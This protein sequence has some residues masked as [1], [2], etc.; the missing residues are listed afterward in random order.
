MQAEDLSCSMVNRKIQKGS[1]KTLKKVILKNDNH[2]YKFQ[3]NIHVN[4]LAI[5][6]KKLLTRSKLYQLNYL[7][8]LMIY[9]VSKRITRLHCQLVELQSICVT[10]PGL[11]QLKEASR[12][13]DMSLATRSSGG[14]QKGPFLSC[15]SLRGLLTL[16]RRRLQ[17]RR[18]SVQAEDSI[19]S[20][21]IRKIYKGSTKTIKIFILKNYNHV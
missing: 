3:I 13:K 15:N 20:M 4:N 9:S 21:V 17:S 16:T 12:E 11:S 2:A 10:Y 5:G 18:C 1:T 14:R 6:S 8:I 7:S 19:C